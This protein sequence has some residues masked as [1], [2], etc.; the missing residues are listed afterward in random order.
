MSDLGEERIRNLSRKRMQAVL[1]I[2][3]GI[4]LTYGGFWWLGRSE[5][6]LGSIKELDH[7]LGGIAITGGIV[8]AG[9]VVWS[10][11]KARKVSIYKHTLTFVQ[12]L[13][14][15]SRYNNL[16]RLKCSRAESLP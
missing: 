16:L 9:T 12:A 5:D 4:L 1:G 13:N 14:M 3:A 7:T 10:Y 2:P 15:V 6:N 11:L 8:L